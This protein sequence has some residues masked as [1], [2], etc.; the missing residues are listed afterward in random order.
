MLHL[1]TGTLSSREMRGMSLL[2]FLN[3]FPNDFFM[4]FDNHPCGK[5]SDDAS[6]SD[7]I[8]HEYL[9][10]MNTFFHER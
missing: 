6:F 2:F 1:S 4:A 5:G 10:S 3:R 8:V 7:P 9:L